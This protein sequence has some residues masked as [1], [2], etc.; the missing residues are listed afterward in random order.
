MPVGGV[1]AKVLTHA[2]IAR[3]VPLTVNEVVVTVV[4]ELEPVDAAGH[5]LSPTAANP[6]EDH[7]NPKPAA[8]NL[9]IAEHT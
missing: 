6:G 2:V 4:T 8:N 1:P 7:N 3:F 5:P 9:F